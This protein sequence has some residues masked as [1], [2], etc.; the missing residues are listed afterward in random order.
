MY[1]KQFHGRKHLPAVA[2]IIIP[3]IKPFHMTELCI[4]S[5]VRHTHAD[6]ELILIN[7]TRGDIGIESLAHVKK[8]KIMNFRDK[9]N[10]RE[11]ANAGIENA[12][13]EYVLT[14]DNDTVVTD[15]W[16]GR[17]ITCL[18][19]SP[20][21]GIAEPFSNS[22]LKPTRMV[23]NLPFYRNEEELRK[24]AAF[25]ELSNRK[26]WI[27]VPCVTGFCMLIKRKLIDEI[28]MFDRN[29]KAWALH[30]DYCFMAAKAGYECRIVGDVFIHHFRQNRLRESRKTLLRRETDHEYFY[31]KNDIRISELKFAFSYFRSESRRN[32]IPLFPKLRQIRPPGW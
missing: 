4:K 6:Y 14:L 7:D 15:N 32:R 20:R 11:A 21:I 30:E 26:Y 25:L 1:R 16:L 3:G 23:R 9:L 29:F 18:E 2:S 13:G 8:L 17:M 22:N 19:S 28:G 31:K 27:P 12:G 10:Y 5:I 24:F